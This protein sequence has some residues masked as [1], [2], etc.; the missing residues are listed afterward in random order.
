MY[1]V[2]HCK[3]GRLGTNDTILEPGEATTFYTEWGHQNWLHHY[4][5]WGTY[6]ADTFNGRKLHMRPIVK[7]K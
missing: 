7:E 5:K 6:K 1:R 4:K 3:D 2:V